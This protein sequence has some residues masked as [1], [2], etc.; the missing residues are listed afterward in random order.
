MRS[1]F[2][3]ALVWTG[4]FA[5]AFR[6]VSNGR[7]LD[8]AL[9]AS[10]RSFIE[11]LTIASVAATQVLLPMTEAHASGGATAG[12][13]Y[14]LSAKQRYNDRVI[15]G[16]KGFLAL[17]SLIEKGD[18]AG[19]RPYFSGEDV[20]SWADLTTAGYLLANAFRRNST[21]APDSLPSVKVRAPFIKCNCCQFRSFS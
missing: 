12:G 8:V 11:N 9:S 2:L 17:G 7:K 18:F 21:A 5:S 19:V 13:V 15:A 14:L 20:G 1:S 6:T 10:R 3:I 4:G 16:V